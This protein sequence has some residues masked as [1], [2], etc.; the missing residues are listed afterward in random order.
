[1]ASPRCTEKNPS[2]IS[3]RKDGGFVIGAVDRGGWKQSARWPE[4]ALRCPGDSGLRGNIQLT[5]DPLLQP[6]RFVLMLVHKLRNLRCDC[7]EDLPVCGLL[8]LV[9][10]HHHLTQRLHWARGG[11]SQQQKTQQT[12]KL[13][14]ILMI[15]NF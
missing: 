12:D 5:L 15:L 2:F 8:H 6:V 3:K 11:K 9:P 13:F 1:M 10:V 4:Y 7:G 14:S